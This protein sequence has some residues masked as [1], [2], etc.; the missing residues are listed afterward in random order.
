MS[1]M[2]EAFRDAVDAMAEATGKREQAKF[3]GRDF[4]S[5]VT[6]NN[7]DNSPDFGGE[8]N[9][10][11][12]TIAILISDLPDSPLDNEEIIVRGKMLHVLSV[13][14]DA[15]MWEITAGDPNG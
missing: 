1:D 12:I 3:R 2:D 8:V 5:V 13:G 9:A 7:R 15:N 10:G 14:W 4:D 6:Q 11:E